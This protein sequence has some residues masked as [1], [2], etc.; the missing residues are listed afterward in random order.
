VSKLITCDLTENALDYIVLAGEQASTYTPRMLKHALATLADG[1]E[2]LVK[3]PIEKKDW[4][5]LFA[6]GKKNQ[7][8][9]AKYRSGDFRSIGFESAVEILLEQCGIY[10]SDQHGALIE[11][12]KRLRNLIRHFA[13][14]VNQNVAISLIAQSIKFALEFVQNHIPS[15]SATDPQLQ[16]LSS[17]YSGFVA[18]RFE[19]IRPEMTK[20]P[21]VTHVSCPMCLQAAMSTDGGK[22]RCA[23]CEVEMTGVDA[24]EAWADEFFAFRNIKDE[25]IDP[26]VIECPECGASSFVDI[27]SAGT[28]QVGYFCFSCGE[29]GEYRR[30]EECDQAFLPNDAEA[31]DGNEDWEDYKCQDCWTRKFESDN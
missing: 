28:K 29:H 12:L 4:K 26:S 27:G 19:E 31:D 23:F 14:T 17:N 21:W 18:R 11:R 15:T 13:V 24:A 30:C 10:V 25:V 3:A 7:P 8:D 6:P 5:L 9:E 22:A 16:T 2:L 1:V 20:D